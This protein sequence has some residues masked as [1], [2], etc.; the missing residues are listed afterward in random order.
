MTVTINITKETVL[1]SVGRLTNYTGSK[2]TDDSSAYDRIRTTDSDADM[3]MQFWEPACD[4]VTEALKRFITSLTVSNSAYNVTLDLSTSYDTALT[5]SITTNLTNCIALSIVS[6]W[7]RMTNKED[8]DAYSKDALGQLDEAMSKIF[9][10]KK[11]TRPG[12]RH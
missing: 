9:Y 2:K 8:W 6:R 7:Y 5:S 4:G 1:D 12:V 11:P 10:K 3:L